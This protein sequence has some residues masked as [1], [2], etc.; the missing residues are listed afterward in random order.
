M[1][2]V[3]LFVIL[4]SLIPVWI[5]QKVTPDAGRRARRSTRR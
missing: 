3:V 1:N 4:L 5:A 2:V